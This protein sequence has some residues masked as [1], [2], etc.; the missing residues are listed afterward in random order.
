MV[1][2]I[3]K[4]IIILFSLF[5]LEMQAQQAQEL[6]LHG[7]KAYEFGEYPVALRHYQ[8]IRKKGAAVWYNMGNCY[9]HT[10]D[11]ARAIACWQRSLKGALPSA[12]A[13]AQRNSALAYQKLGKSRT[14]TIFERVLS[15]A[16][17][18]MPIAIAQLLFLCIWFFLWI[19]A[20]RWYKTGF[21][22][23]L[24]FFLCVGVLFFGMVLMRQYRYQTQQHG[25]VVDPIVSLYAGPH[26]HFHAMGTIEIGDAIE[27]IEKRPG[28]YKV[29]KGGQY[30]WVLA[31]TI[32]VIDHLS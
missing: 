16:T 21:I 32:E 17:H 23:A 7:N 25:I 1:K 4:I 30:G 15:R 22:Y 8:S 18:R 3:R 24:M 2:T 26:S 5:V 14:V 31:D 10:Q 20:L 19:I 28:W 27:L 9:Y 29:S 6:F 12:Y 13:D 11:Y